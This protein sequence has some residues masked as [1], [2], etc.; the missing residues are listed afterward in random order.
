MGAVGGFHAGVDV[1][2]LLGSPPQ[3]VSSIGK[4]KGVQ[5]VTLFSEKRAT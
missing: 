2:V 1:S 3:V 4:I 5:E